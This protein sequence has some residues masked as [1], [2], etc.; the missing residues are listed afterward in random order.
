VLVALVELVDEV[1]NLVIE[2]CGRH[3]AGCG[4]V[5]V[6]VGWRRCG[7]KGWSSV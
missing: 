5:G 1:L 3:C 4:G 6:L 2:A 7:S